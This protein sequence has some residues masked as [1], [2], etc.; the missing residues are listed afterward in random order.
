MCA[1]DDGN[2]DIA[3]DADNDKDTIVKSIAIPTLILTFHFFF[4]FCLFFAARRTSSN[5]VSS[6]T[7]N[8]VKTFGLYVERRRLLLARRTKIFE[9]PMQ[10]A[11]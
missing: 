11:P 6:N 9:Q 4:C 7:R 3:D 5:R 1:D 8:F 2:D 10:D